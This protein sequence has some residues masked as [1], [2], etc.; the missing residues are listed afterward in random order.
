[1][2]YVFCWFIGAMYRMLGD[3]KAVGLATDGYKV[4]LT[5]C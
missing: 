4:S 5:H 2:K 1:M 3:A